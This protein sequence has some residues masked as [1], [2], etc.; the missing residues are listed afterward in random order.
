MFDRFFVA[1]LKS[2]IAAHPTLGEELKSA[3]RSCRALADIDRHVVVPALGLASADD[4]YES[5]TARPQLGS[6]AVPTLVLAA[7]D[8]PIAPVTLAC[9]R[10]VRNQN[11]RVEALL[12][13]GHIG[14]LT[15][16]L[17]RARIGFAIDEPLVGFCKG[18]LRVLGA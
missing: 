15:L 12:F 2:Y 4:H 3:A 7:E 16:D 13:G 6:V 17:A 11:L 18:L 10:V 9:L 5:A 1:R 8:D 14:F